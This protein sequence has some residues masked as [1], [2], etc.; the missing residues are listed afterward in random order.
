MTRFIPQ[1][2]SIYI[3]NVQESRIKGKERIK[4]SN[5]IDKRR[6]KVVLLLG[7]QNIYQKQDRSR[8][9]E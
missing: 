2:D 9:V 3:N 1:L 5:S 8:H 6:I 4:E 7:D